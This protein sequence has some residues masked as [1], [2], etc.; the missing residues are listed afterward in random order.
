MA[1]NTSRS[2]NAELAEGRCDGSMRKP[3]PD[4]GGA[5][6]GTSTSVRA[7]LHPDYGYGYVGTK[8]PHVPGEESLP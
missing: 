6:E 7:N 2:M 4:R 1:V 3:E 5:V 8:A